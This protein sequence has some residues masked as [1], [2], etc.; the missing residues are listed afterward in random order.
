[1]AGSCVSGVGRERRMK[2]L[3]S[4]FSPSG[5]LTGLEAHWFTMPC[6]QRQQEG[7]RGTACLGS[8]STSGWSFPSP[9]D[10][11]SQVGNAAFSAEMPVWV[12]NYP[13]ILFLAQGCC[14]LNLLNQLCFNYGTNLYNRLAV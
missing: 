1:M 6:E 4:C 2:R 10:T 13:V 14:A 7:D 8:A 5:D 9:A 3:V 12:I 11:L